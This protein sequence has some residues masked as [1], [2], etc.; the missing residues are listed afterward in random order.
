MHVDVWSTQRTIM[1]G[2]RVR[3]PMWKTR[4]SRARQKRGKFQTGKSARKCTLQEHHTEKQICFHGDFS[5]LIL[6]PS[7]PPRLIHYTNSESRVQC[8]MIACATRWTVWCG[9]GP[10]SIILNV[11]W[12]YPSKSLTCILDSISH[13]TFLFSKCKHCPRSLFLFRKIRTSLKQ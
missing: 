12:N 6:L 8:P 7:L 10:F 11:N 13:A 2:W 9:H 1:E 4:E 3:T 5:I